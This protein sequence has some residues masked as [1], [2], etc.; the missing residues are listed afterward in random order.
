MKKRHSD[1][2]QTIIEPEFL[3]YPNK[4]IVSIYISLFLVMLG[5]GIYLLIG[6]LQAGAV[7]LWLY[8][9]P[10]FMALHYYRKKIRLLRPT[11]QPLLSLSERGIEFRDKGLIPWTI[12][13]RT[14]LKKTGNRY[15][16][17]IIDYKSTIET[18]K[19][20]AAYLLERRYFDIHFPSFET[21]L[22]L[23][24]QKYIIQ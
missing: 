19:Y 4:V 8:L 7:Y 2:I 22:E 11:N 21:Q 18:E 9:I 13:Q 12:I 3:V 17:L 10:V 15:H 1:E 20:P 5:L 23:Y 14:Y 24:A 6:F 16:D